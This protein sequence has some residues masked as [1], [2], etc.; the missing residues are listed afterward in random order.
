VEMVIANLNLGVARIRKLLPLIIRELPE[1]RDA[2]PCAS[3]LAGAIITAPQLIPE[4]T[5]K[6]LELIIGKYIKSRM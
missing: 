4:K 1:N 2:C 5:Y 3:A 6:K